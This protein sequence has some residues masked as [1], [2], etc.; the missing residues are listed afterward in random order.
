MAKI[1]NLIEQVKNLI[2]LD[3]VHF[4]TPEYVKFHNDVFRFIFSNHCENTEEWRIISNNLVYKSSQFMCKQ[5]ANIILVQLNRLKCYILKRENDPLLKHLHPQIASVAKKLYL[6]NNFDNASEN[7]FKEIASRV[8][9][10]FVKLNPNQQPPNNDNPL[11]TTVFSD[12]TPMI[13]FCDR[14]DTSGKNIQLGYMLM[15]AG[16]MSALRNPTAHTNDN[17]ITKADCNRQLMFASM[18]MYKI[19]EAVKYSKISE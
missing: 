19:D 17:N 1:D 16:A 12:K 9:K 2:S 18:L 15:L 14:T 4:D 10:L 5:E 13:E 11:M 8:R 3:Y 6:E 7:A